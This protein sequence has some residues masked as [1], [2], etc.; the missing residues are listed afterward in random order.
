M[1]QVVTIDSSTLLPSSNPPAQVVSD[2]AGNS[3]G[4][5]VPVTSSPVAAGDPDQS[6]PLQNPAGQSLATA[7]S[8]LV[9]V[10]TTQAPSQISPISGS[11][12]ADVVATVEYVISSQTPRANGP[13]ITVAGTMISLLPGATS[14]FVGTD[15]MALSGLIGATAN[16]VASIGGIIILV[17]GFVTNTYASTALV[18]AMSNGN[19]NGTLYLRG[20][21]RTASEKRTWSL[22]LLLGV[23]VLGVCW[24]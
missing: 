12:S 16:S 14:V 9:A 13:A 23:G 3:P 19:Y 15:T 6:D 1:V 10:I 20:A 2:P 22:G 7:S 4:A 24:L 11:D 5:T 21:T 18:T 17:G 8:P